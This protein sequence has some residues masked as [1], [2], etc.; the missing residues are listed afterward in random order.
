[1]SVRADHPPG[2]ILPAVVFVLL[3]IELLAVTALTIAYRESSVANQM[4]SAARAELAA[5]AGLMQLTRDSTLHVQVLAPG[6]RLNLPARASDDG[7]SHVIVLERLSSS[8]FLARATGSH[9]PAQ[10]RIRADAVLLFTSPDP[11]AILAQFHSALGS[12]GPVS[13][14]GGALADGSTGADVPNQWTAADCTSWLP[15]SMALTGITIE[16]IT[17]FDRLGGWSLST[18]DS[19]ADRHEAGALDLVSVA[20]GDA[21]LR[22]SAGNWGA[23][24][25]HAHPCSGYFP[26]I[27]SAGDL[28]L[29]AGAGQGILVVNGDLALSSS[30]RFFGLVL[31]RGR[32]LMAGNSEIVGA[33]L[34]QSAA[35]DGAHVVRSDCALARALQNAPALNRLTPRPGRAWLPHF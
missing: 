25:V 31:V 4:T 28:T 14:S 23:P 15:P 7:A 10:R 33:V 30:T 11:L 2:I 19:L 22:S 6:A 17:S 24:L 12:A 3:I 13:L 21:C 18:V 29:G 20:S 5:R 8:L 27:Y 26:L 32:L 9:G 16:P 35:L 34:A 1:M